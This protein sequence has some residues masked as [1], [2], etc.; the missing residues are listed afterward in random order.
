MAASR[1]TPVA[2]AVQKRGRWCIVAKVTHFIGDSEP[3]LAVAWR[4]QQGTTAAVSLPI[5]V[6]EFAERAGVVEFFLRNDR[7]LKMLACPLAT[8]H[9]GRLAA[10][11]ERY[12]PIS[13]LRP[14]PWRDWAFAG[15]IIRLADSPQKSGEPGQLNFWGD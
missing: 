6:I 7:L 11:G 12:V 14:V 3:I 5:S 10:D 13:W 9:R 1:F 2:L 4:G 15:Q 8:F